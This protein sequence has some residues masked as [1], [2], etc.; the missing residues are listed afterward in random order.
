MALTVPIDLPLRDIVPP[1]GLFRVRSDLHGQKHVA[2]VMVHA[3]RL[4]HVT[5]AQDEATRLWASVYIHDLARVHDGCAPR[6]GADAWRRLES[7]PELNAALF[8][9]GVTGADLDAVKTA[10]TR[11]SDGEVL[12]PNPHWRLTALLKDADA[13]DRVRLGDLDVRLLRHPEAKGM[14]QFAQQLLD[15]TAELF[16]ESAGYFE[17]LWPEALRILGARG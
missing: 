8:R 14:V 16:P 15:E 3:F 12:P 4:L 7:E 13:L 1:P 11:H 5:G 2:R 9:G 17:R 6:H 10:V